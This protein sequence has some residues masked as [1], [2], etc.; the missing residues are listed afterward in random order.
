MKRSV[1]FTLKFANTEKKK[2]LEELW[3]EYGNWRFI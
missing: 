2:C 3:L 1:K